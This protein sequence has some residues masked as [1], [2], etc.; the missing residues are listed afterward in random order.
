MSDQSQRQA[1]K[2]LSRKC[3]INV[4]AVLGNGENQTGMLDAPKGARPVW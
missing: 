1:A 2:A 4:P 3:H